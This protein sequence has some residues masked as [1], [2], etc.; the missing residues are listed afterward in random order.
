MAGAKFDWSA[1]EIV[2]R[3]VSLVSADVVG[4]GGGA[5]RLVLVF[6]PHD[7]IASPAA[8]NV[9]V[10]KLVSLAPRV[11]ICAE[12]WWCGRSG[13]SGPIDWVEARQLPKVSAALDTK[14]ITMI[15]LTMSNQGWP[16]LWLNITTCGCLT[17]RFGFVL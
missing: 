14:R 5:G 4:V 6:V 16:W 9:I 2:G 8:T 7:V 11:R 10:Q 1:V 12:R 17:P 13:R 3:L 15:R